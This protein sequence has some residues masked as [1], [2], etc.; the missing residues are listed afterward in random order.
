MNDQI[1]PISIIKRLTE[2]GR[3]EFDMLNPCFDNR[4]HDVPGQH[5][6]GTQACAYCTAKAY[7]VT[8]PGGAGEMSQED[9]EA[10]IREGISWFTDRD[11]QFEMPDEILDMPVGDMV[12]I[13]V[14]TCDEDVGNR[15]F[16]KIIEWQTPGPDGGRVWLCDLDQFNYDPAGK[17]NN[18]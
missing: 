8:R 6:D 11:M 3:C 9:A 1:D 7:L 4:P 17:A 14:S 16:G 5:S 13:D 15:V 12:S 18:G 10:R 2:N